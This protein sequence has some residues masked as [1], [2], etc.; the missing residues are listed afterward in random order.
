VLI[1]GLV[2]QNL[3]RPSRAERLA[4]QAV[5]L[6]GLFRIILTTEEQS[7]EKNQKESRHFSSKEKVKKQGQT[8]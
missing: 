3:Y 5:R 4:R 1:D 2:T 7:E 6:Q 8:K